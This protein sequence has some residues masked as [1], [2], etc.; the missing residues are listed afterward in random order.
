MGGGRGGDDGPAI[1]ARVIDPRGVAVDGT[2]NVYFAEN[3]R[4]RKVDA[5]GIIT[6]IV[7]GGS[8]YSGDGGPAIAAR[9]IN[10]RGVAVDGAGNVYFAGGDRIRKVDA[11]TGT[12]ATIAGTGE[13]GYSGDGGPAAEAQ[14]DNPYGVA[15]D[16]AGNVYI[17]DRGNNRIRKIDAATGTIATIAGTGHRGYSGDGGPAV[18]A[19]LMDPYGVAVDGAGNV[20]IADRGNYGIRKVDS[21][22]IITTIAGGGVGF[23]GDG[24]PAVGARL[25][26]PHGVAVDGAGNVYFAD[27]GNHR[28]RK[29]N[30]SGIIT[31]IAGTG[32]HGLGGDGGL[33]VEA[34]LWGP[35]G[36]A[37]DGAGNVYIADRGNGRIRKLT[38]S[39]S[40]G[41]SPGGGGGGGSSDPPGA[42]TESFSI[43]NLGGRSTTSNGTERNTQVGYGRIRANAGSTTPSGIAIIG[44]SP[45]GTL[46]AEAGVPATEP[47][48]E[49]RIFAEVNGP[50][51]TG[52]AIANP[53]DAPATIAF[54]FTDA[55]GARFGEGSFELGAHEQTAKFLDQAPFNGGPPYWE[56]LRLPHRRLSLS[57]PSVDSPTNPA[58]S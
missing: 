52:L 23:G 53:N 42:G 46:F 10:P 33:A 57:S 21:S 2:G 44:Y 27:R 15:V 49:G 28:I 32:V 29:V 11:A 22:G 35:E 16:G 51:N 36:V 40:S 50:V 5:L 55:E 13:E 17:A 24:G 58:S 19:Q 54:Y 43:S 9:V 37:V 25:R 26:S 38:P 7:G 41:I 4:I 31:T 14:I 56:P 20:Y 34:Q 12:I 1:A 6:T 45:G 39:G 3:E 30:A 48:Q 18:G 47:I 8:G